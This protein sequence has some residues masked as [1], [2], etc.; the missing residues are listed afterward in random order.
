LRLLVDN[1]EEEQGSQAQDSE[2]TSSEEEPLHEEE[3]PPRRPPT[4]GGAQPSVKPQPREE[5]KRQAP[6]KGV[7]AT[8][9]GVPRYDTLRIRGII[10]GQR[11]ITLVDGGETHN[12]ID[13]AWVARRALQTKEFEGLRL[14]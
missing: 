11:A 12:F 8:L 6:T 3:Q 7:I 13:A 9:S 4:P 5:V 14:Q 10:Q 1:D 2:S